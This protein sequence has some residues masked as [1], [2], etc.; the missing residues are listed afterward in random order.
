MR[1]LV[2]VLGLLALLALALQAWRSAAHRAGAGQ[3]P[4]TPPAAASLPAAVPPSGPQTAVRSARPTRAASVLGE[5][6]QT[7][8]VWDLCGIGRLPVPAAARASAAEDNYGSLPPH[9]GSDAV[10]QARERVLAALRGG[11]ARWRAA[12]SLLEPR[13]G[14]DAR[15]A[16]ALADA[17][18]A[19]DD[20][21]VAMWALQRCD[22]GGGC[23][24]RA[25]QRW[26]DKEPDNAAAWLA[27][28]GQQRQRG[29]AAFAHVLAARRFDLHYTALTQSVL[30][31]MPADVLPYLQQML[32]IESIGIE[33]AAG[34]PPLRPV[35]D[36]CREPLL[37]GSHRRAACAALANMLI[38]HSDTMIGVGIG[39]RLAERS[40]MPKAE[41][42]ARRQTLRK[43]MAQQGQPFAGPEPQSCAAVAR[44]KDWLLL[45]SRLGEVGALRAWAASAPPR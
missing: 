22:L 7:P 31:A 38:D 24:A 27:V 44:S 14:P 5:A 40:G 13:S 3:A 23:A 28:V 6:A 25:A 18:R 10:A 43:L 20:T 8:S 32:W 35:L 41:A 2:V 9:L 30:E 4:A 45:W 33:A 39:L 36:W 19:S 12:A 1:A 15:V 26:A 11:G 37:P 34:L 42:E 16:Q 21:V 29:E 17:A